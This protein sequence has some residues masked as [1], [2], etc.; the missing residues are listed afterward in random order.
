MELKEVPEKFPGP[1]EVKIKVAV[2]G[3]CGTDLKI[4]SGDIS[5]PT[6][7]VL[8]HEFSGTIEAIGPGV[9]HLH[10]GERVTSETDCHFCGICFYCRT[11]DP[12]FCPQRKGIGTTVD[13]A[14]AQ[15]VVVPA[16]GVHKIPDDVD[17]KEGALFEPL[18]V[19]CHAVFERAHIRPDH[20]VV[21]IGVGAIG[22]LISQLV[23]ISGSRVVQIGLS[24][25]EGRLELAKKWGI[26]TLADDSPR[27][28]LI[29][30]KL[31][32][33]Q[34]ADFVFE[35]SGDEDSFSLGVNLLKKGGT[36][37]QVGFFHQPL[38]IDLN[39]VVN[40]EINIVS[41]R[42]KRPSSW[43]LALDLVERKA[44]DLEG[45]ITHTFNFHNWEEGFKCAQKKGGVKVVITFV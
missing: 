29:L 10:P 15:Y 24:R 42:G 9:H 34:G 28:D 35:C 1:G 5:T 27:I 30:K 2:C 4:L 37:V 39:L 3:I 41:S 11:G 38:P 22:L 43:F 23:K 12:Q 44:I 7:V 32:S 6:P 20:K 13:G 36:L 8:G 18:A 40:K 31:E 21:V 19:A 33:H 26:S 17:F 16:S 25:H 45:I 14:F